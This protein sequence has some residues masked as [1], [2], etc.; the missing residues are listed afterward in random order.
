M[1]AV[2]VAGSLLGGQP[3]EAPR[4][5][6]PEQSNGFRR[7]S[8][9]LR[10]LRPDDSSSARTEIHLLFDQLISENYS[11][12]GGVAPQVGGGP[13]EAGSHACDSEPH[14]SGTWLLAPAFA[15]DDV[16]PG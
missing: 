1:A 3:P 6:P 16:I 4:E 11:E 5:T 2:Q 14:P 9:R 8:A 13:G 12:S 7:L 15:P 10:A